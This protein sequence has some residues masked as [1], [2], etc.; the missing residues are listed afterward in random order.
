MK[1]I[2]DKASRICFFFFLSILVYCRSSLYESYLSVAV[3]DAI[4]FAFFG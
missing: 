3:E 1:T 2:A 4:A